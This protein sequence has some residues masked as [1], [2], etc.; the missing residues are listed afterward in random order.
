MHVLNKM[1]GVEA[2]RPAAIMIMK[3]G[4]SAFQESRQKLDEQADM[5]DRIAM[6]VSTLKSK[7]EALEGTWE[8]TK[9]SAAKG[10]GENQKRG[11]DWAN[12]VLGDNVQPMVDQYPGLGTGA[13]TFAAGSAGAATAAG[14][15]MA[16]QAVMG[17]ESGLRMLSSIPG[18]ATMATA[19]SRIPMVPK[20]AGLFGLAASTGGAVLSSVAGED[21]VA[22]RYGSSALSGAGLGATVG[23][24]IPGIGTVVGAAV[25]GVGALIIQGISDAFKSAE[26]KPVE[27]NAKLQVGLAPGLVIQ[28][29]TFESMSG[30]KVQMNTGNVHTGAP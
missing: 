23:S 29:Q 16:L 24:L 14:S 15:L 30:G 8:N 10:F 13:I 2:S 12:S 28:S 7:K 25:G 18:I 4:L 9:A 27:I 11:L 22:A 20:G 26:Q 21:S 19:A 1:F 5:E 6:K 3:G 17:T